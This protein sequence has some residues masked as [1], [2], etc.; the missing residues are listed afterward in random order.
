MLMGSESVLT[1]KAARAPMRSAAFNCPDRLPSA[2]TFTP[3]H[4][5]MRINFKPIGPQPI[6]TVVSPGC[7]PVS[8][9]P[10]RTQASGSA[11]AASI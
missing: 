2:M 9:I 6:N 5:S 11:I 1:S 8:W 3:R 10:R 4:E 7:T